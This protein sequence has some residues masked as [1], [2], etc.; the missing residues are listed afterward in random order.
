[1]IE[2]VFTVWGIGLKLFIKDNL[3]ILDL[4]IFTLHTISYANELTRSEDIFMP[5]YDGYILIRCTKML[6]GFKILYHYEIFESIK[7]LL[8]TY[9]FTLKS[10]PEYLIVFLVIAVLFA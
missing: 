5:L 1:M 8:K 3:H 4:F 2:I 7:V 10:I 9:Y 6:R